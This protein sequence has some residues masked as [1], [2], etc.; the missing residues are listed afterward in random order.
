MKTE[1]ATTKVKRFDAKVNCGDPIMVEMPDGE[2]RLNSDYEALEKDRNEWRGNFA[3]TTALLRK[4]RNDAWA[5]LATLEAERDNYRESVKELSH[6]ALDLID[7]KQALEAEV[8]KLREARDA[9]QE[10]SS[11]IEC[12]IAKSDWAWRLHHDP[13]TVPELRRLRA[14]L[15]SNAGEKEAR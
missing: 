5:K 9:A 10:L 15:N 14:A 11:M 3:S 6:A 13:Q 4:E 2:Y 7:D 12:T 8:Q 1:N